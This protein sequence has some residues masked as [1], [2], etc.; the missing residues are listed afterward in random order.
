MAGNISTGLQE[1]LTTNGAI[2]AMLVDTKSGLLL[3]SEGSGINAELAAA[4]NCGILLTKLKTMQ[5]LQLDDCIEDILI[6]LGKQYHI[7]RP[8]ADHALFYI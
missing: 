4:G 5:I 6:T 2:I 7:I 3:G 8:C 1:A